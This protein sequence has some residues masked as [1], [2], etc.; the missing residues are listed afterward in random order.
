MASHEEAEAAYTEAG[1]YDLS[2]EGE[3]RF[4]VIM[5]GERGPLPDGIS[6]KAFRKWKHR[7]AAIDDEAVA[8]ADT[9]IN[10]DLDIGCGPVEVAVFP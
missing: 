10:K 7:M 3:V 2:K 1:L 5:L 8:T 6:R 4:A 9:A